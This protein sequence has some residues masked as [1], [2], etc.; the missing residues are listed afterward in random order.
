MK[1]QIKIHLT[2]L[3][4]LASFNS[5]CQT[6]IKGKW[7]IGSNFNVSG[8]DN[9]NDDNFHGNIES[10]KTSGYGFSAM[11][12]FGYFLCKWLAVGVIPSYSNTSN[13][14]IN[15]YSNT[16]GPTVTRSNSGYAYG[17]SGFCRLNIRL[18]E[19]FSVILV[20]TGG[21]SFAKGK[22][23]GEV[24][25]TKYVPIQN[26]AN[27]TT[28]QI[29]LGTISPGL[30]YFISPKWG[31]ETSFCNFGYGQKNYNKYNVPT[32]SHPN[33]NPNIYS[34]HSSFYGFNM[35]MTTINFGFNFYF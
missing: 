11:P 35:N 27:K 13:S 34:L 18:S 22:N 1:T 24:I 3:I 8:N 31:F 7:F 10:T 17:I 2:V 4:L 32:S 23:Y 26:D 25:Y 21:Y 14:I 28:T 33:P 30:V 29:Y 15:H 16:Y 9:K 19:K 5:Y 20:G 12:D 6:D